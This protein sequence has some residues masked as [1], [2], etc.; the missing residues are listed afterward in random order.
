MKSALYA[1]TFLLALTS[2]AFSMENIQF[3]RA[4]GQ[5]LVKDP[6]TGETRLDIALEVEVKTAGDY[7][8]GVRFGKPKNGVAYLGSERTLKPGVQT[9]RG[10]CYG[11]SVWLDKIDLSTTVFEAVSWRGNRWETVE[12]TMPVKLNYAWKDFKR[13]IAV[14][15]AKASINE[16]VA[17]IGRSRSEEPE[18]QNPAAFKEDIATDD[19]S[20]WFD[21]PVVSDKYV[22]YR[23][24]S[25]RLRDGV[26][27]IAVARDK[28]EAFPF[29]GRRNIRS[30]R[31]NPEARNRNARRRAGNGEILPDRPRA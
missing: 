22:V 24:R 29:M 1:I 12:D 8:L 2:I 11:D 3:K 4:L 15:N 21:K 9:L 7:A 31:E 30:S 26:E 5:R 19:L 23:Y 20:S 10:V 6:E 25:D 14:P 16:I 17:K 28:S 13:S 18:R 27:Y